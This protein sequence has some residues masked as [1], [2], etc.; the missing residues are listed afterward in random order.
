MNC[1]WSSWI[2]GNVGS[3]FLTRTKNVWNKSSYLWFFFLFLAAHPEST[4][5]Q[6]GISKQ[7]KHFFQVF[8]SLPVS[9]FIMFTCCSS[10]APAAVCRGG[11]SWREWRGG[12]SGDLAQLWHVG[13]CLILSSRKRWTGRGPL[14][15]PTEPK[16]GASWRNKGQTSLLSF[17]WAEIPK[18]LNMQNYTEICMRWFSVQ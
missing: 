18:V 7:V 14:T 16:T 11:K 1:W 2:V 13:C 8:H 5:L 4:I 9:A 12:W 17:I 3:R 6:K 15:L 10:S